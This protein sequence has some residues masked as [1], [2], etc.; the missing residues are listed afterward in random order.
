MW[1][2]ENNRGETQKKVPVLAVGKDRH[3]VRCQKMFQQSQQV[4]GQSSTTLAVCCDPADGTGVLHVVWRRPLLKS[5]GFP[6][7]P[8]NWKTDSKQKKISHTSFVPVHE[9]DSKFWHFHDEAEKRYQP[10]LMW[11]AD[12]HW[13]CAVVPSLFGSRSFKTKWGQLW[14]SDF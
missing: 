7:C 14:P 10:A 4:P 6:V 5:R 2:T 9:M 13:F 12:F 1:E 8:W 11:A 3:L